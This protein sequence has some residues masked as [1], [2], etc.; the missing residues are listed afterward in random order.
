M[1][2]AGRTVIRSPHPNPL[3]SGSKLRRASPFPEVI[4]EGGGG[5]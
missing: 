3:G 2:S 5:S 4:P 1:N